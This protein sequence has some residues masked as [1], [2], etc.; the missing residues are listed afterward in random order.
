MTDRRNM[1][2]GLVAGMSGLAALS[3]AAV[4]DA[5]VSETEAQAAI[6]AWLGALFTEDPAKVDAVLAPEF[7]ILRSDGQRYDK[8][9]YLKALPKYK[10]QPTTSDLKVT[11]HGAVMVASYTVTTDQTVDGQPVAA[12]APRLSV[13]HKERDRWLI[14]AHANFARIG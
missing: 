13:F 4:A 12:V 2:L 14:V 1:V 6:D 3:Q 10:K 5:A 9:S 8:V 7:Q 11:G